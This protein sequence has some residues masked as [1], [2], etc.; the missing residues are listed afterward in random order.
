MPALSFFLFFFLFA[1]I[2]SNLKC[3]VLLGIFNECSCK[4]T[5]LS[6]ALFFFVSNVA[7]FLAQVSVH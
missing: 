5:G 6:G 7:Y 3:V 1:E 2:A 4:R